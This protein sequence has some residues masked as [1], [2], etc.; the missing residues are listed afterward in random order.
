MYLFIL[1][2]YCYQVNYATHNS[3]FWTF[4]MEECGISHHYF[5]KK[6]EKKK[7]RKKK[8]KQEKFIFDNTQYLYILVTKSD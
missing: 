3:K 1:F 4:Y 6:K 8:K 5:Y 2:F 7:K